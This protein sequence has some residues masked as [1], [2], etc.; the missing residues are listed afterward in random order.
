[1]KMVTKIRHLKNYL[2]QKEQNYSDSFKIY[3]AYY[4]NED[5]SKHNNQLSFLNSLKSEK[6]IENFV[7][8]LTSKFVLKFDSES[9]TESDFIHHFLNFQYP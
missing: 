6:D 7:D 4:F 5:F 9:E 2:Y 3:I 8:N 1:M